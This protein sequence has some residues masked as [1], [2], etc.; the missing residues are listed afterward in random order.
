M[1]SLLAKFSKKK[2]Y[3]MWRTPHPAE[4]LLGKKGGFFEKTKCPQ[5]CGALI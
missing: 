5:L 2:F 4:F 3:C 1:G